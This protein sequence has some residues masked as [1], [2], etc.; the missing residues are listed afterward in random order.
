MTEKVAKSDTVTARWLRNESRIKV[1]RKS[2]EPKS[3]LTVNGAKANDLQ[4]VTFTIPLGSLVGLCGVSGS[5][6]STLLIDTI[7][8]ALAPKKQTTSVAYE[9]IKPGE[10]ESIEGAPERIIIL[11]QVQKGIRSPGKFLGLFKQLVSIY[12]DCKK[13]K[14]LC[15]ACKKN[16]ID[17]LKKFMDDF[18]EKFEKAKK[19]IKDIKFIED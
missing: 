2:R 3:W 9:P 1:T 4:D 14:I 16:C 18:K 6:K 7:G 11:D 13:G 15:G 12:Q 8:R 5:G 17:H 19:Q 10:Y